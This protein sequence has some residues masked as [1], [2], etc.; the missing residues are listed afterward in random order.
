MKKKK[1]GIIQANNFYIMNIKLVYFSNNLYYE[2]KIIFSLVE[3]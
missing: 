2:L 1:K 3:I